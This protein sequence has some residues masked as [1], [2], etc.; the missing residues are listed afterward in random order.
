MNSDTLPN[1]KDYQFVKSITDA[2]DQYS[3]Q[4]TI[5]IKCFNDHEAAM[6]RRLLPERC[7]GKVQFTCSFSSIYDNSPLSMQVAP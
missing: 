5:L 3:D 4:R 2:V 7:L 1:D 6:I